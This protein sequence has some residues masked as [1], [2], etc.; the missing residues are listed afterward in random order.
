MTHSFLATRSAALAK[1]TQFTPQM[2]RAYAARRNHAVPDATVS[3][4]SPYLRRRMVQEPEVLRAALGAH[5]AQAA[6]KFIAEVL[7]RSYFKGWLEHR[8][9]VWDDYLQGLPADHARHGDTARQVLAQGAGIECLDAWTNELRATGYLHN[10]ARM[11]FAA[12]WIFTLGL[13]WRLGAEFFL[14]HLLDGCPASNT[15]SWRWVAGL[16]TL[17]KTYL[18]DAANIARY[19]EGRFTP[20]AAEVAVRFGGPDLP[21][22]LPPRR[23]LRVPQAPDPRAP[24]LWL[25]TEEDLT[26]DDLLSALADLRVVVPMPL[27]HLRGASIAVADFEQGALQDAAARLSSAPVTADPQAVIAAAQDAGARQ[28]VTAYA[29]IG[30]AHDWLTKARPQIEAAGMTLAEIRRDW[31]EMIWPHATAGFFKLR[32]KTPRFLQSL[33]PRP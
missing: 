14:H 16:H 28:I 2:G 33:E 23:P 8:P 15:L 25:L 32:E 27:S 4:L 22:A 12:I 17:G 3:R 29:P 6:D 26:P 20:S 10:H 7:W 24:S 13:P 11:W 31:D 21:E 9:Q 19:T 18:P 30:P 5:G 1:V